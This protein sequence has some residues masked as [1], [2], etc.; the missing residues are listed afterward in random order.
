MQVKVVRGNLTI[1]ETV[2]VAPAGVCGTVKEVR[3]AK[4]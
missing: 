4:V 1:G 3:R 2:S